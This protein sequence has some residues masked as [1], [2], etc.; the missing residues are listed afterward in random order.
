M[1]CSVVMTED[2]LSRG[3][4]I[5]ARAIRS[6]LN[7]NGTPELRQDEFDR[8]VDVRLPASGDSGRL[9]AGRCEHLVPVR[10]DAGFRHR[11]DFAIA[12]FG[13]RAGCREE[14]ECWPTRGAQGDLSLPPGGFL[15]CTIFLLRLRDSL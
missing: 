12:R 9:L 2:S 11:Q 5:T 13:L 7:T 6:G 1:S 15:Q 4:A 10:P 14:V 3:P 8:L